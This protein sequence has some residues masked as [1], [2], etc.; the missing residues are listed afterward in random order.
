M[1]N[2]DLLFMDEHKH[3]MMSGVYWL[4]R[5]RFWL[6]TDVEHRQCLITSLWK[7]CVLANSEAETQT[8]K[9]LKIRVKLRFGPVRQRRNTFFPETHFF[10]KTG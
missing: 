4:L 7:K 1:V 5:G 2:C 6:L 8:W 10:P 3:R 9:K